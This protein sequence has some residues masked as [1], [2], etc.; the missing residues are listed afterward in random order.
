MSDLKLPA[1]NYKI[2]N[3]TAFGAICITLPLL[4][5]VGVMEILHT[6]KFSKKPADP[7]KQE[8]TNPSHT[9]WKNNSTKILEI[10]GL[11]TPS[12]SPAALISKQI[13]P[14]L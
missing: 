4:V 5:G 10:D 11:Q 3:R 1:L 9:D 2:H 13:K 14:I 12:A 8:V 7:V 6:P